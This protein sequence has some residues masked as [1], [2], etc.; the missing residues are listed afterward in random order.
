[1]KSLL[2]KFWAFIFAYFSTKITPPPPPPEP[3]VIEPEDDDPDID[4]EELE[5]DG[6][7]RPD[8]TYT[9]IKVTIDPDWK[10]DP[11]P[12]PD[13]P[14]LVRFH[15]AAGHYKGFPGKHSPELVDGEK[16]Y[17]WKSNF[18]FNNAIATLA[19][20]EGLDYTNHTPDIDIEP[21]TL[22]QRVAAINQDVTDKS[23]E[24]AIEIHSNAVRTPS[25]SDWG[26]GAAG[27]ETWIYHSSAVGMDVAEIIQRHLIAATGAPNRGIKSKQRKQFYFLRRTECPAVL[28]EINFFNIFDEMLLLKTQSYRRKVVRA[29]VDALH[30]INTAGLPQPFSTAA[31]PDLSQYIGRDIRATDAD[32][33]L[34]AE[35]VVIAVEGSTV[36]VQGPGGSVST[37]DTLTHILMIAPRIIE[38][39]ISL[40]DALN[41]LFGGEAGRKRREARRAARKARKNNL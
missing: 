24:V 32:G 31:A 9:D 13:V 39:L 36:R 19:A 25:M 26:H 37:I 2:Q 3:V 35:G 17:E 21:Y 12:P 27:I 8:S 4:I 22:A 16:F 30:E 10:P 33:K 15:G 23:R 41:G 29:V 5:Q 38:L 6:N 18:H 34:V 7:L 1:M 20:Q 11:I 14:N 28:I 40:F